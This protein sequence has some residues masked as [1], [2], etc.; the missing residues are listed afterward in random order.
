VPRIEQVEA[1]TQETQY[2][3]DCVL[4][5]QTPFNDGYAGL[6]V[7]QMLEAID[8]SMSQKGRMVYC[9]STADNRSITAATI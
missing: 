8:Q 5:K 3:V 6:R 9:S 4:N 2:F 7:V 1:L